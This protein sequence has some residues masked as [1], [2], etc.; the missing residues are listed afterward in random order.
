MPISLRAT[1]VNL[2]TDTPR[3]GDVFLLDTNV[4]YWVCYSKALDFAQAQRQDHKATTYSRYLNRALVAGTKFTKCVASLAELA[5]VIER[6]ECAI[7]SQR[8]GT[9][10]RLKDYRYDSGERGHVVE[11]IQTAWAVAEAITDRRSLP[12]S[13][14]VEPLR[15]ILSVAI[16]D[17]YDLLIYHAALGAGIRQILTDDVD[18]GEF[19]DVQIFTANLKLINIAREQGKLVAR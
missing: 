16:V 14:E 19:P 17:G 6:D 12:I 2:A 11:E 18:Y 3:A 10:I 13:A 9:E 5:H 8:V 1:V 15:A 7:F 4:L